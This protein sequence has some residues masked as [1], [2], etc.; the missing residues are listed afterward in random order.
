[1]NTAYKLFAVFFGDQRII[2]RGKRGKVRG[3]RGEVF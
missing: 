3:K 2:W 1:M